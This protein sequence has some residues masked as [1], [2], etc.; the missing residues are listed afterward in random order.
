M[1]IT[2]DPA[3]VHYILSKNY[4]DFSKGPEVKKMFEIL[5]GGIFIAEHELWENQRRTIVSI[6]NQM[7]FQKLVAART[8]WN[9]VEKEIVPILNHNSEMG[10]Q[11]DLQELF[12]RLAFDSTCLVVLGHDPFSLCINLP[13]IREEKVPKYDALY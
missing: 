3:D 1:F 6:M 12:Q 13:N 11:M 4:S 9:K 5:G 2:G 8:T 10:I 7:G